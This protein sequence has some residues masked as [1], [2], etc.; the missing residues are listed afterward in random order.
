VTA[1]QAVRDHGAVESG[2]NVL[3]DGAAGGAGTFGVQIA[4]SLGARVTGVCS[5]QNLELVRSIGA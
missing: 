4:K 1:L 3:I 2:Q 5:T